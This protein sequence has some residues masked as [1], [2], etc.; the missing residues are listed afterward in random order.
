MAVIEHRSGHFVGGVPLL[1]S[2]AIALGVISASPALAQLP[3]TPV[4]GTWGTNGT[5]Y[6]ITR[7]GDVAYLGGSFSA[8]ISKN[9]G[10]LAR[11]NV[12]AIDLSTG[13]PTS[14][15]PRVSGTVLALATDAKTIFVGG[16]FTSV[17]GQ[18]RGRFA[19][20]GQG[21]SLREWTAD[22][23][24]P[25]DAL[26]VAGSTLFMGGDF[27]HLKGAA[28]GRLAA[29]T[30]KG[31][32]LDWSPSANARVRSIAVE[33][34][35]VLVA[36]DF[37]SVN[38]NGTRKH[39]AR[40]D[41]STGELKDFVQPPDY[42]VYDVTVVDRLVYAAIA[43][44]GGR[45]VSWDIHG[46][47]RWT[48]YADGDAQAIGFADGQ[49]IAGGHWAYISG[50]QIPRL[51]GLDPATGALDKE[52]VPKPNTG[53]IW[54]I[55]AYPDELLVGGNDFDHVAGVWASRFARFEL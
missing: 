21:G 6:A 4:E 14:W 32:L 53:G 41:L 22:A 13:R 28:R 29:I 3:K 20:V 51:A 9:G 36:G 12:A 10:S 11:S 17:N 34:R 27:S 48:T 52:W 16:I 15:A 2:A 45:I 39:V 44:P 18:P 43:G 7:I 35:S 1:V 49:V 19:A 33:R 54:A 24:G 30:T 55:R 40:L 23:S 38:G 46:N 26:A 25:V 47:A 8:V 42:R 50:T 5:V 37:T 31:E